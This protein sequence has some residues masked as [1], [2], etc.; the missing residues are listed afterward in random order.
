MH[1]IRCPSQVEVAMGLGQEIVD[2][3]VGL[4]LLEVPDRSS[5]WPSSDGSVQWCQHWQFFVGIDVT[6]LTSRRRRRVVGPKME[7]IFMKFFWF[8]QRYACYRNGRP[9]EIIYIPNHEA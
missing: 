3:E 2:V 9:M 7:N 4:L 5:S 8:I 6:S 1:N